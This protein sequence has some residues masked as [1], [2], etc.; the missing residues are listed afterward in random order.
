MKIDAVHIRR[1]RGLESVSLSGCANLNVFIG[2]N[3]SGK[4]SVLSAIELVISRMKSGKL[5]S[6]WQTRNRSRD[7]FTKKDTSLSLQIGLTFDLTPQFN[8]N[9]RREILKETSGLEVAVEQLRAKSK[10]SII[11]SGEIVGRSIALYVQ[12]INLGAINAAN[13]ELQGDGIVLLSLP[14]TVGKEFASRDQQI[15]T[16]RDS[17]NFAEQIDRGTIDYFLSGRE[18][19]SPRR[20]R[21]MIHTDMNPDILS[22]VEEIVKASDNYSQYEAGLAR[23]KA[24]IESE[25]DE[26]Q[27][28]ETKYPFL[29][30]SGTS[31]SAPKYIPWL[32]SCLSEAEIISFKEVRPAVGREEAG[33]I[34][35]FKTQRG[36]E[37]PLS[38][39][40][41]TVR[42][43]L[44]VTVDAFEPENPSRS[45]RRSSTIPDAEMD[46]D[47]FLVEANGAGIR[48]AL[49]IILDLELKNPK[50]AL[51]EEPEVHLHPGLERVLFSYLKSK[52]D[53]IQLFIATHSANF[54][55]SAARQNVY[56][57]TKPKSGTSVVAKVASEGD[58]LK[59]SEEVGLRPSTVLMFD[60][61]IFVEGPSD[62]DIITELSKKIE[63]NLP[64]ARATFVQMGGASRFAHYAAEATLELLSRRQV[65]MSFLIDR[66]ERDDADIKQMMGK[67]GENAKLIVLDKRELE[68]YI[69]HPSA[70]LKLIEHKSKTIKGTAELPSQE[71]LKSQIKEVAEGLLERVIELRVGKKIL[72]PIYAKYGGAN[73]RE[74]LDA[75][76]GEAKKRGE[77][78]DRIEEEIRSS[79]TKN[80]E[81]DAVSIVPGS[82]IL[83]ELLKKHGFSYRKEIDGQRLASYADASSIDREII[84]VVKGIIDQGGIESSSR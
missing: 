48:E 34:L 64:N 10:I 18:S 24:T 60:H 4:S 12:E 61:L 84:D 65:K 27:S 59:V 58:L 20:L 33:Q 71:Q 81:R 74:R 7:E 56:L 75:M 25:I 23:M 79:L 8:E 17:V 46:I 49:R 26:L 21:D 72:K 16:W 76:A 80:W 40:K 5:A 67:V 19:R 41:T 62:E 44:G 1:F 52:S 22:R 82:I 42:S 32:L 68:N 50:I 31:R 66:D 13:A 29:L 55:D 14:S 38:R 35:K 6:L 78:C 45:I 53:H 39:I 51:I 63:R 30:I 69:L 54:L 57:F 15:N 9:L 73:A 83:D 2:R 28:S 77:E 70:I 36:G 43:L 3:N 11:M 37:E 47:D